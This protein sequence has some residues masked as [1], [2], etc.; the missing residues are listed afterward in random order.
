MTEV[1]QNPLDFVIVSF[2]SILFLLQSIYVW[3]NEDINF[4]FVYLHLKLN[5]G[6]T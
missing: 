3:I 4:L 5:D 6:K 2:L 1:K